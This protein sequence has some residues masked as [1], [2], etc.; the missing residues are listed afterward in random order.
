[1]HTFFYSH[2][3]KAKDIGTKLI[4]GHRGGAGIVAENSLSCLKRGI[5]TGVDMIEIDIPSRS[6]RVLVSDEELASRD[7]LPLTRNRIVSK[8][9]QHYAKS[10]SSADLGGVRL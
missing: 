9:L 4:I 7:P 5:D 2:G 8:A 3:Y 1:M 10:V 6:I